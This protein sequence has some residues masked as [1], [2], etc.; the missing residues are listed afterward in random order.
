MNRVAG[1]LSAY[2]TGMNGRLRLDEGINA[3]F[4]S[5]HPIDNRIF[6]R[7]TNLQP[8]FPVFN[9]NG[10]YAQLNGTN[11]ENPVELNNNRI[12]DRKR[13]R[14]LGYL[15]AELSIVEGL[16]ATMN[17]SYESNSVNRAYTSPLMH[18]WR[19][20]VSMDGVKDSMMII[21]ISSLNFI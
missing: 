14:F 17:T 5:W 3:N 15:K 10:S 2:Q 4:D 7:M 9:Q 8:T 1:S 13:H 19:G 6:E 20:R 18:A 12:E 21:P 16:T 11:T